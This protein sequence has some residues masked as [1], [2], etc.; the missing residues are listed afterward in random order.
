VNANVAPVWARRAPV[1]LVAGFAVALL[2]VLAWRFEAAPRR[3]A[4]PALP[5]AST[6]QSRPVAAPGIPHAPG[7]AATRPAHLVLRARGRCWLSIRAD[8]AAGPVLYEATLDA[9]GILRFTLA[10]SRPRLWLR[11]GAPWNLELS[12]N[13]K[14]ATAL[15]RVPGNVL[16]TRGGVRSA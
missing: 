8:S 16:V 9:G 11:I 1:L 7:H 10:P 2:G 6:L 12:L 14:Q 15:P 5:P 3:P 4:S 13:G